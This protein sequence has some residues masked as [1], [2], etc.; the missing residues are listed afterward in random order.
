MPFY[1]FPSFLNLSLFHSFY[2]IML[3][4]E[5]GSGAG[6]IFIT[7]ISVAAALVL[8]WGTT[9]SVWRGAWTRT[10]QFAWR[11]SSQAPSKL[12]SCPAVILCTSPATSRWTTSSHDQQA[13][14]WFW[15]QTPVHSARRVWGIWAFCG[16]RWI[17]RSKPHQCQKNTEIRR[18]IYCVTIVAKKLRWL[19]M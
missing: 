1:L 14:I 17:G 3:V 2:W 9:I 15:G 13:S 10:V 11:I 6:I 7:A 19:S 16:R 8:R 4:N 5:P 18:C 12:P